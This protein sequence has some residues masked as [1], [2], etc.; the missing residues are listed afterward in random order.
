MSQLTYCVLF[1]FGQ[2][3]DTNLVNISDYIRSFVY[4][5]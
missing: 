5:E 2:V 4:Q 1:M 3:F